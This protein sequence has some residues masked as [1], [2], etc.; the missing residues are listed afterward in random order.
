MRLVKAFGTYD[1][2]SDKFE[3][4]NVNL[5]QKSISAQMIITLI[6]PL[7]SL[8]V[9]I[10]TVIVIYVGSILFAKDLANPEI[11]PPLPY[12]MAQILSSLI[13]ITNIFNT[14]VRT[15][16]S[17]ARIKE[18]FDSAGDLTRRRSEN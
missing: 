11:L 17:T 10:G 8:S 3:D 9:G 2:E 13:M 12:I 4:A 18:V 7:M 5:M 6:S 1:Q 15:K 16:A 14:F